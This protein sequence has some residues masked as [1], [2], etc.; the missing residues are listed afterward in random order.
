MRLTVLACGTI[1]TDEGLL[2]SGAVTRQMVLIPVTCFLVSH[3][4]GTLLWDTGMNPAVR[5]DPLAHWGGAAKRAM[6]PRL[7]PGASVVERLA[8]LD[9]RPDDVDVVLNSHL[10]NDHSGM[11]TAFTGSRVLLRERELAHARELMD[12][13]SSGFIRADF[14]GDGNGFEV[15]DYDD[16]YDV[17]GDASVRLLSTEGHTPGHQSLQ[18]TFPSGTSYILSGDA[19]Y[20]REQLCACRASGICWDAE[21]MIRSATRLRDA[22]TAGARVLVAHD[23]QEWPGLAGSR[24]VREEAS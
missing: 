12:T 11:N 9:L 18:V 4:R 14:F 20:T 10:H 17:F 19:V 21:A 6:V 5:T 2:V 3:P 24:V 1:S 13:P 15:F 22:E 8:D 23:P 16:E 7:E